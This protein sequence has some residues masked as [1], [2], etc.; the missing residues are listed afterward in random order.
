M[1]VPA[2]SRGP[3]KRSVGGYMF[4][5]G[6][7]PAKSRLDYRA[8]VAGPAPAGGW[9]AMMI[10]VHPRRCAPFLFAAAPIRES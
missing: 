6:S 1:L 7:G 10:F 9:A 8:A 5:M 2:H 4:Y 3:A